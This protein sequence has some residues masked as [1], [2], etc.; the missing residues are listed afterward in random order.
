[1][2]DRDRRTEHAPQALAFFI[3]QDRPPR[4]VVTNLDSAT[5]ILFHT[6]LPGRSDFANATYAI[7]RHST[8][9][10]LVQHP[11]LIMKTPVA[12]FTPASANSWPRAHSSTR[13]GMTGMAHP[14]PA[15]PTPSSDSISTVVTSCSDATGCIRHFSI[16]SAN[17]RPASKNSGS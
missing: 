14:K 10:D 2:F 1:M 7:H 13:P 11:D 4:V 16:F 3:E 8:S 5:A 9:Y 17:D 12:D 6:D 15:T